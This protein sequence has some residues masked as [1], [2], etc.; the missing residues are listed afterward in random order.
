MEQTLT[1]TAEKQVSA[2]TP[3][4]CAECGTLFT[5]KR[6]HQQFCQTS[7][8]KL[9]QNRQAVEGRALVAYVKAW[10]AGRNIKGTGPDADRK[11]EVARRALSEL[12]SVV[13][14]F[15]ADDR[16]SGRMD[17]LAYADTLLA[18]CGRYMD[19]QRSR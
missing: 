5:R 11:R 13:D 6:P 7:C 15:M 9:F 18:N 17:P 10:R 2:P 8:N 14:G 16:N 3:R 19:R 12:C 4:R 1:A